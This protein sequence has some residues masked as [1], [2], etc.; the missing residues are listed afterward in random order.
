MGVVV[1]R[2]PVGGR[3]D[4]WLTVQAQGRRACPEL[5]LREECTFVLSLLMT[6]WCQRPTPLNSKW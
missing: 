1:W 4:R 3:V 6:L 2:E 5:C